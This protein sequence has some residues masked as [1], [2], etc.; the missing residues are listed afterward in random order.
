[1]ALSDHD[2]SARRKGP[3][4]SV[5]VLV[6]RMSNDDAIT[7][8]QW[9]TDPDQSS[10]SIAEALNAEYDLSLGATTVQRHRRGDCR[11]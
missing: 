8:N 6:T 1:M 2:L 5:G 3:T 11:C 9:M 7:F 10:T 4:C